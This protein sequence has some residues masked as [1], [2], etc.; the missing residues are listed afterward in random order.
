LNPDG[1]RNE[2]GGVS[3]RVSSLPEPLEESDTP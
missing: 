1:R 3:R 2:L